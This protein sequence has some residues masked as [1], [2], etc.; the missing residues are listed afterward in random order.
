MN[1]R[2]PDARG[3]AAL[4]FGASLLGFAAMLVRWAAPAGPLA[5]GFYRMAIALP[6]VAWMAH[7]K[8]RPGTGRARLWALA[9]GVCF[10]SDLWMWHT[11]LHLT[12][13]AN[14]TLLVTLAPIWVALVSVFWLGAR[15]KRR[16]WLG[17]A[18]AT[19]GGLV[20][21]LAKGARLGTGLG[22]LLGALASLAYAAFA[23][24]LGRARRELSAPEAL[25]WVVLCCTALFGL[26][27]WMQG[28]VFTG[29]PAHS[30]WALLGLGVIV[31]V[32]AWWFITWG[33]GHV[34]T[35]L[36]AMGLMAQPAATV[37]LGWLLL[38]E[39]LRPLQALGTF[40]V[41]AGIAVCVLTPQ[42][43]RGNATQA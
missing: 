24:A 38:A 30:W 37:L 26:L 23:L 41:L 15:L 11:A 16:F 29:Y 19:A 35:S 14:A 7:G 5:V 4:I 27:G 39:P 31:Q 6:L 22:E 3:L 12:S 21:G 34:S 36:G 32:V 8:D 13:A 43:I 10:V 40:L 20:L 25:F 42:E 33:M 28:E 1:K 2:P 18:A 9:A 17:V